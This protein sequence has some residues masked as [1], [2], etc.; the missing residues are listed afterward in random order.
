LVHTDLSVAL[1]DALGLSTRFAAIVGADAA[2][3]AKPDPRHL[4]TTIERAGGRLDRAVMSGDSVSDARAAQAAGAPL[5][6][7]SF[8]YTDIPVA[9]LGAD[10]LID[11]FDQ[12]PDAC[13]RLLRPLPAPV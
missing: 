2:P 8:G 1:L 6:L 10:M 9:D 11:H 13:A 5:I 4:T 12:L 7:V 3:A